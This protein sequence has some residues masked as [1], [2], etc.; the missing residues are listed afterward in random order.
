[1][2]DTMQSCSNIPKFPG[3]RSRVAVWSQCSHQGDEPGAVAVPVVLC[4]HS[5]IPAALGF[6]QSCLQQGTGRGLTRFTALSP[7]H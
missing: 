6:L 7:N 5:P 4:E 1:M 2:H 3:T